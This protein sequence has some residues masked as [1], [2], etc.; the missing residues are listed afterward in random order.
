MKR[1]SPILTVLAIV[2]AGSTALATPESGDSS[3]LKPLEHHA[4]IAKSVNG[5]AQTGHYRRFRV[6]DAF[7]SQVLDRYLEGL[8]GNKFYF[9]ASDIAAFDEYRTTLDDRLGKG[10][11]QPAFDVFSVYRDRVAERIDYAIAQLQ[12][13]P[14][15]SIDESFYFDRSEVP[16]AASYA[17]L[18]EVWRNRVKN[19]ALSLL[20]TEKSW[21]ETAELLEKRYRRVKTRV[22][23]V[24]ADDVFETF[25]N[26]YTGT[27]DPHS[28]YFSP[29][30]SEE[31][32]I[33]MSLS[34]SGIGASLQTEDDYVKV[35]TIIPGGPAAVHGKPQPNDRITAVGQGT[36]G[37]MVD[38]IGWRLDD[39]VQMIRGPGGTIVRL[40]ILPAG[41]APGSP[42]Q[43]LALTRGQVN[44]ESQAAK[45]DVI[46][47]EHEGVKIGIIDVPSFYQD[48]DARQRHE[49]DY[50]STTADVA[51]LVDELKAEGIDALIIDLRSNG[52]GH[53]IEARHLTGLFVDGPVV[54]LRTNRGREVHVMSDEKVGQIYDGPLVVLVDR[55][56]ASASEI[57]A[58]AIQ[59]YGRGVV[60][61]QR[62]FG[63]GSVQNLYPLSGG[64]RLFERVASNT[65]YG[66]LTLTI[67][68]YYRVTGDSTQ[69]RGVLP[70]IVLPSAVDETIVGESTEE[71]AL[72]W[73]RINAAQDF[74]GHADLGEALVVLANLHAE[75]ASADPDFTYWQDL[76]DSYDDLRARKSVSLNLEARKAERENLQAQRLERENERR[77]AHGLE[78]LATAEELEAV[79]PPDYVLQEAAAIAADMA[80]LPVATA[81]R[82]NPEIP[83]LN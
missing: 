33:Q 3:Q 42:E 78:P 5:R 71:T 14:D 6:D 32:R 38:V 1:T 66:Q 17:E 76:V 57:F 36:D 11:V 63:K 45:K 73:D 67:G 46:D 20:L 64:A 59:D 15:F 83:T 69:H 28:S 31:Y 7:S 2:V 56:S 13:E 65:D 16:W 25:M 40:Q 50:R 26:A 80:R 72:D 41:A 4:A 68:K 30:N 52:G 24:N 62:T 82:Q 34:Y 43:T 54:Q 60:V 61:G 81:W 23:Q 37:E 22:S 29:R 35:M 70:D 8:D 58:G 55:L 51:R 12:T 44:L 48:Y 79:E 53:L 75:R 27:L 9:R 47:I 21:E 39:V 77:R 74:P 19:D 18:N 10:D 49:K